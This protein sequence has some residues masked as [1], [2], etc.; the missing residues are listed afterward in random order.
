M[1]SKSWLASLAAAT[2]I[3]T[4]ACAQ[5]QL[6]LCNTSQTKNIIAAVLFRDTR[7]SSDNWVA[8]GWVKI[9]ANKCEVLAETPLGVLQVFLATLSQ[10]IEGGEPHIMHFAFEGDRLK[11]N[12]STTV[13]KF[14]CVQDGTFKRV[15]PTFGAHEQCPSGWYRQLFN[16]FI[17]ADPDKDFKFSLQ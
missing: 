13:E 5:S 9:A 11:P 8:Y 10:R 4:G 17:N 1:N 7:V 12:D 14:Y 6:T 3:C 15:L 16:L 2:C